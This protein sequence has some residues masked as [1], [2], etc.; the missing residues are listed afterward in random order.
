MDTFQK[1]N[2]ELSYNQGLAK[3]NIKFMFTYRIL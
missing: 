1:I 3:K 2:L